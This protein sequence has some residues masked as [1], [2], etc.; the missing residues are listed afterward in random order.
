MLYDP[1]K[2]VL[3]TAGNDNNI[4]V[5]HAYF[6]LALLAW[7]CQCLPWLL[8]SFSLSMLAMAADVFQSV[9]EY[10]SYSPMTLTLR[11]KYGGKLE[12]WLGAQGD[13]LPV[14][15]AAYKF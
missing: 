11:S 4:N 7:A 14:H 9:H 6:T 1:M 13:I 8:M 5:S 15:S 12:A 3:V 2:D 10:E